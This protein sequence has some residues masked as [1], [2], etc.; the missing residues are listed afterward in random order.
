[1]LNNML[2]CRGLPL[3]RD[4]RHERAPLDAELG[5][6]RVR[7]SPRLAAYECAVLDIDGPQLAAKPI[8]LSHLI[9]P[10]L[11]RFRKLPVRWGTRISI[12]RTVFLP[13]ELRRRT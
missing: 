9:L 6:P 10:S 4:E 7:R 12:A 1:M 13:I 11:E 3:Y 2:H 5:H 8:E